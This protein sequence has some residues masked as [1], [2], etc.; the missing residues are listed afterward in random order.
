VFQLEAAVMSD[1][2]PFFLT[3]SRLHFKMKFSIKEFFLPHRRRHRTHLGTTGTAT[4]DATCVAQTSE[5]AALLTPAL[6]CTDAAVVDAAA[7]CLN[8]SCAAG[9][10]GLVRPSS[11]RAVNLGVFL[12]L[13]LPRTAVNRTLLLA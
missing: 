6:K 3:K 8:T 4:A 13:N 7:S 12:Q 5:A 1:C 10:F 2:F 9:E 11:G